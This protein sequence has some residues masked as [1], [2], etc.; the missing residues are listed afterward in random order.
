MKGSPNPGRHPASYLPF[1][2][3]VLVLVVAAYVRL[4]LLAVPLERDEG[5]FAYIGQLLLKGVAPYSHAYTMKLPGVG[6]VY[7]LFMTLFGQTPTGIHLGLLIVNGISIYLL[8]LLTRRL[9]DGKA[10]LYA[11][12]SYAVLS[13][14]SSVN[15]VFAHATHF[16]VLFVLAGLLTL[17]HSLDSKKMAPMFISGLC[18][19]LAVTMKQHAALLLLYAFL[20]YQLR[21]P[22]NPNSGKSNRFATSLLFLFGAVVPYA[23][24]A[25]WMVKSGNFQEFWLWTVQYA[26]QYAS[27]STLS[28]GL[29]DFTD[30]FSEIL[31]LQW[32][33][34][35]LAGLG[36]LL[37]GFNKKG[38]SDRI[39]LFGFLL[40]S[41]LA[42]CPGMYFRGHYFVMLLP[43][44]AMA[45]GCGVRAAELRL[46]AVKDARIAACCAFLL[47]GAAIS[48]SLYQ[49]RASFFVSTPQQVSRAWYGANPF[50]EAQRIAG[51]LKAH[52]FPGDRIA[53]FGSEPEIYF[54]ADRLSATG[55]IYMYGMMENHP[56]TERM[57]A[58]MIGDI[59]AARPKYIV[60]VN[61]DA[62]WLVRQSSL[63]TVLIWG[64]Q[65][66][67]RLYDPVGVMDIIDADTTRYL[68]DD[69][70][71]GYTPRSS[72]FVTVFKRKNL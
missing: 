32:P 71:V 64:E 51:Y 30:S 54:Y 52:T 25:L 17:F 41:F 10:A 29:E 34:W 72:S 58:Q 21:A 15:G 33:L 39:F 16:V 42:V 57:Q 14:S 50:P 12:A 67:Q 36:A 1:I 69:K 62:S 18:F 2:L 66:L 4:R 20:Y 65:Y 9:I 31:K 37:L 11:C 48:Y 59:E 40:F 49:E 19:G 70:A 28:M 23:L 13:L 45:A 63:R 5:E 22:S 38:C 43:A 44:V 3:P 26:G 56:F 8:Y 6:M 27:G 68:W 7:A 46:S 24:I 35:L 61:V 53:V 60:A 55:H 47:L